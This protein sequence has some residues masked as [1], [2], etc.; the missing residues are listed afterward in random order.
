LYR[1]VIVEPPYLGTLIDTILKR[2]PFAGL[3]KDMETMPLENR[4]GSN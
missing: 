1:E 2:G 4:R 3:Q